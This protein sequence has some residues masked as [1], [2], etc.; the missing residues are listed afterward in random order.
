MIFTNAELISTRMDYEILSKI[1]R[2]IVI[3]LKLKKYGTKWITVLLNISLYLYETSS[4]RLIISSK[5]KV[6]IN[7]I[8]HQPLFWRFMA[9]YVLM[10]YDVTKYS[11]EILDNDSLPKYVHSE[12]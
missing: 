8:N 7:S 2:S 3:R 9:S 6:R 5:I 1:V 12:K 4:V 10:F 11:E